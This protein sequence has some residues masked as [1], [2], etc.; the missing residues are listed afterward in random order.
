MGQLAVARAIRDV[1][2]RWFHLMC[3]RQSGKTEICDAAMLD[4][5][6]RVP[7][8]K[9]ILLHLTGTAVWEANWETKWKPLCR[10]HGV[11]D[12]WHND[13]RMITRFPNGSRVMFAGTDDLTHVKRFLGNSLP[14]GLI[15]IDESQ[16]QADQMLRY[17]TRQ[18]LVPMM[19]PTTRVVLAGVL[20]DVEAGFFYDN[21]MP[22]EQSTT[23]GHQ[24]MGDMHLGYCHFEWGRAANV[25]AP[26]TLAQYLAETGLS[27]DD[28]Q[29]ARDWFMLRVWLRDAL[30]YGYDRAVNGYDPTRAEWESELRAILASLRVP[31]ECLMAAVPMI[32]VDTFSVGID[33]G[34]G[35]RF[36]VE[37]WGWG[38][39]C[40]YVQHVFDFT[41]P[42]KAGLSW[43]RVETVLKYVA[44]HYPTGWWHYDAQG[45]SVELDNF[46][47]DTGI[48]VISAAKKTDARGQINR[49]KNMFA[50]KKAL[51]M[52][53]SALETDLRKARRDPDAPYN[54]PWK[55]AKGWPHPDPSEAA[56]YAL[57]PYWESYKPPGEP[58]PVPTP[59]QAQ[60]ARLVEAAKL[61]VR[62]GYHARVARNG[63]RNNTGW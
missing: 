58:R 22:T 61:P 20:P 55:W 39:G 46:H 29:I 14:G 53:G 43:G 9:N 40:P 8:S 17:I 19:T 38:K 25:H 1:V 44:K 18:L 57:A 36:P 50:G 21:A 33:P 28:P 5:A 31:I 30:A 15:I 4:N 11:P 35:D 45:S 37:V 16:D 32:G 26:G 48:P 60:M 52:I 47:R 49:V 6:L 54:G 10:A 42:R 24:V 2:S 41:P 13:T 3:A 62:A 7:G 34:G 51:V 59:Y 56:R 27:E 12:A 23:A 63:G